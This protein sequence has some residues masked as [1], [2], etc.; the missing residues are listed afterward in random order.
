MCS[1]GSL[2]PL[3]SFLVIIHNLWESHSKQ[4]RWFFDRELDV[5]TT[6]GH[7]HGEQNFHMLA[8]V[9]PISLVTHVYTMLCIYICDFMLWH[10][11]S[12][13]IIVYY[14]LLHYIILYQIMFIILYCIIVY[15]IKLY[16]IICYYIMLFFLSYY[17][18]FYYFIL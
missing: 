17:I 2:E 13:Y 4:I 5:A 10:V 15:Y 6:Y 7:N 16:V 9:R 11:I 12:Y 1:S 3:I 8:E 18:I 14:N